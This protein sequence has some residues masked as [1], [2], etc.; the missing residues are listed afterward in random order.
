MALLL[1]LPRGPQLAIP[2][3]GSRNGAVMPLPYRVPQA[4]PRSDQELTALNL[5]NR[6]RAAAGLR[7]LAPHAGLRAAARAHGLELFARGSLSHRSLDGRWPDQRLRGLGIRVTV[8]GE[9]LAYAADV[10]EAHSVLMGSPPHRKN[11]L[12][13]R[14]HLVGIA[15]LDGGRHGVVVVQN[16]S[17]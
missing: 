5:V 12:S 2:L 7:P 14:F 10:R 1:P 16:F 4:A 9:N 3:A 17:D 8:V 13:P 11:L 15:V 6:D